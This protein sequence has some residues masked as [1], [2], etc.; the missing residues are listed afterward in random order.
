MLYKTLT[1]SLLGW[2]LLIGPASALASLR[3]ELKVQNHTPVNRVNEPLTSGIPIPQGLIFMDPNNGQLPLKIT[4]SAGVQIP[5]QFSVLAKW[6][7]KSIKWV[8]LD[9]Q[10]V[11][12][13]E[14]E[15]VY[16][17]EDGGQGNTP[18]GIKLQQTEELIE[19]DTGKLQFSINK[20]GP[21]LFEQ[22]SV[23]GFGANPIITSKQQSGLELTGT[24]NQVFASYFSPPDEVLVEE[25]GPLRSVIRIRGNF[26]AEDGEIFQPQIARY[27][28]RIHSYYNQDYIRLFFTLENN[29]KYGFRHENHQSESFDFKQ[30]SL[31]LNL[32]LEQDTYLRTQEYDSKYTPDER[33]FLYQH[34]RLI[35][36]AN[37][38]QNFSYTIKQGDKVAEE[39]KRSAGWLEISDSRHEMTVAVRYFWQNYPKSITFWHNTLS[40][41]LW[42]WGGK[43]PPQ[44]AENYR[45]RGGTHKSYEIL[46]RF[47]RKSNRSL[48]SAQLV[49][50]FKNPLFA[51][52]PPKWYADSKALGLTAPKGITSEDPIIAEA[53]QKYEKLQACKVHIEESEI[54]HE[55]Y[56]PSTVYTER[57]KR[58]EHMDWYGWMDF[59]DIPWGGQQGGGAYSSGHYDWPYGL[60]L[61]FLRSGD[62]AFFQL[63]EEMA[64]H[65]M[66]IDQYHTDRGSPYLNHFQ[67][68]E[69]GNH[70]R[71]REPW[72]P[73]PSHTWAQGL[74]LYHLLTGNQ[75]ARETALEVGQAT[76]TYWNMVPGSAELRIQGW[77]IENLLA[78]YQ[79]TGEQAY[80]DLAVKVYREKTTPFIAPEGYIGN[81]QDLNIFQSVL[82]LEPL[83]KLQ[84]L[85]RNENIQDTILRILD[86]LVKKAYRGGKTGRDDWYQPM[87]L[88]FSLN[89]RTG[90]RVGTAPGYNFMTSNA[91]AYAYMITGEPE[92]L[93]LTRQL[94]KDSVFYWQEETGEIKASKRSPIA[95]AAAHF[96][97]SLSKV[98]GWINRYP[99]IYLYM[100]AHPKMDTIPPAAIKDLEIIPGATPDS[101]ILDWTAPG[102]D[103]H[104]G[105]AQRYQIKYATHHLGSRLEW[106]QAE[107]VE[108]EPA[109]QPPNSLQNF[110]VTHLTPGHTYF[111]AIRAYDEQNNWSP[112][113]NVVSITLEGITA[114]KKSF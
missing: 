33:F 58:G 66:D 46:L 102:D 113:S 86:F 31:K 78:L 47:N 21:N 11:V 49:E 29:G 108:G 51:I 98:H 76:T 92:Y 37:E 53:L 18:R 36:P 22:L 34:H 67:W 50:C 61:Q 28:I 39:G 62:Y 70:D 7:D 23:K 42:P 32:N 5:A 35:D 88:P 84:R 8:L 69:F 60:L 45:F 94:F 43:W 111:F 13:D 56:P 4:D 72:E 93:D 2:W 38:E 112:I 19:V 105:I 77:S 81:P 73:N 14:K 57:E 6:P 96:P 20:T 99:Q 40:L 101:V 27:T 52:A 17:L 87:Y 59:G 114:E 90:F 89:I 106:L 85:T 74:I 82:V 44:A 1:L 15:A 41:G 71:S 109:P 30:L 110:T 91:L 9:F 80:L 97:G 55:K 24:D 10:A 16:Y 103:A 100:E 63:G 79:L 25:Q 75:K 68:N 26:A 107:N 95:Y 12:K 64:R 65:R 83:I 104:K 3:V 54:Q 48:P